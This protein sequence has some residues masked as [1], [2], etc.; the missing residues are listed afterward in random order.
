MGTNERGYGQH[1]TCTERLA[2]AG[3]FFLL[4]FSTSCRM[5]L[6]QKK[7]FF[8]ACFHLASIKTPE[9]VVDFLHGAPCTRLAHPV[10]TKETCIY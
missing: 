10:G 6:D 1:G 9:D 7:V 2:V 5:G 3:I 4:D 8:Y